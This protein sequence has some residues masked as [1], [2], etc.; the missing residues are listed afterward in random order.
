M[1]CSIIIRKD[2]KMSHGKIISQVSHA[3]VNMVRNTNKKI[4]IISPSKI[5]LQNQKLSSNL[6]SNK[7]I[8]SPS[9]N[10]KDTN[11]SDT[12]SIQSKN[13]NSIFSRASELMKPNQTQ[14]NPNEFQTGLINSRNRVFDEIHASK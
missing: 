12:T 9:T 6:Q 11:T 10:T 14:R 1:K 13:K 3:I 7:A 2:L 4:G 5:K 8:P